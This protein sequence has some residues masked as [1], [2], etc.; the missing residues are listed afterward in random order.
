MDVYKCEAVRQHNNVVV[1]QRV[2]SESI[3]DG[4]VMLL[5]FSRVYPVD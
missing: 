4:A 5:V 1:S 2:Q 3:K